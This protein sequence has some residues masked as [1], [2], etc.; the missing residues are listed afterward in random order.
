MTDMKDG[1]LLPW[2]VVGIALAL[3]D[4]VVSITQ[5]RMIGASTAYPFVAGLAFSGLRDVYWRLIHG[6]AYWEVWFLIGG[7]LGALAVGVLTRR[8]RAPAVR[9]TLSARRA[10]FAFGGGFLMIFGARMADG[11][12]SGHILS[13]GMQLAISSWWFAAFVLFGGVVTARL[14]YGRRTG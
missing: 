4:V 6:A 11:C 8:G 5:Q 2:W 3:L 7:F 12:T 13:G 9:T 1:T 14:V 10:A